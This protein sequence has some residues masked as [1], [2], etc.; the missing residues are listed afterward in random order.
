MLH[1]AQ[2]ASLIAVLALGSLGLGATPADFELRG[3][4]RMDGGSPPALLVS[5][6]AAD[7]PFAVS[8]QLVQD[9]RF[10]FRSLP[11]GSYVVAATRGGLGEVRRT[12]VI[13]PSLAGEDRV[14]EF[15]LRYSSGEAAANATDG[16]I[17]VGRLRTPGKA[18]DRYREAQQLLVRGRQAEATTSLLE[19]VRLAPG[20]APAWVALGILESQ[21]GR[22]DLAENHF[23]AALDAEPG[24][25]DASLN[26]GGLLLRTGRA[27]D[28]LPYHRHAVEQRP[29][30]ALANAQLG[31]NLYSLGYLNEAERYLLEAKNID[32]VHFSQPQVFLA[33]I[34]ARRGD[35]A[36]MERE[37]K[38]LGR[39]APDDPV[40]GKLLKT[41]SARND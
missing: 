25:F 2:L 4:I 16:L 3:E 34:Y 41:I 27:K 23:L 15:D 11:A 32:P 1:R 12:V 33:A 29:V 13:S 35:R 7:S 6:F 22:T 36:A 26:L 21:R 37:L 20:F 8:R 10:R 9:G 5:L 19:A 40:A 30:D 28:A 17:S 14:V 18:L 38:D 31:M 39:R 24:D